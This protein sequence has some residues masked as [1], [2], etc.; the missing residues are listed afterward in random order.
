MNAAGRLRAGLL[1]SLLGCLAV[2][3]SAD[4]NPGG[5]IDFSGGSAG[6][7]VLTFL[8]LPVAA[9]SIG[10]GAASLTTDEEATAFQANPAMIALVPDYY[11]S[12]SHAEILGEFRHEN[13]AFTVPTPNYGNFGGSANILAATAFKDARDIDENPATPSAYDI[14]LGLTYGTNLV[15]DRVSAGGRLDLLRSNLDGDVA[16]GYAVSAGLIFMLVSDMR[17]ALIVNN[18]SHGINY[19][20]SSQ[21]PSEPLPINVGLELGKPLL[22]TRWSAQAGLNQGNDGILHFYAGAEWRV[23]KYLVLRAG[24]EGASQDRE[25]GAFGGAAGGIGIKYDRITL[26]YG[27]KSLGPLGDYH[28]F[29]LSYSRK[30]KFRARDE[31][32]LEKALDKYGSGKYASALSL[33]RAAIAANP[34]NFKAQALA[35]KIQL[36]MDRLDGL[37]VTIA[38]TANTDGK[39][40]SEWINGQPVGGLPRRKTKL[41][42]M[43]GAGGKILIVD[44]GD[45]TS[46]GTDSLKVNYVHGAYAQM[47]YD[48]V[49][50][51]AAE[52]RM[53]ADRWDYRLPFL[54]TQRPLSDIHGGLLTEKI[55]PIKHGAEVMLL[56]AMDPRL[57]RSEAV[58]GKELEAVAEALHRRI[59]QPKD[60]RILVLLLHGDL[61]EACRVAK[62]VPEL[63]A[64]ILSG[65]AQALRSPMK[66]GKTLICSPGRGGTN[67]G[68]LTLQLT[69]KGRIRSFRHFLIPLD[70]GVPEDL[71]LKQFLAPATLDP[72]AIAMDDY[73]GDFR[74]QII[75][76]VHADE[77]GKGGDLFLRDLLSGKDYAVPAPGLACSRPALGYGKNRV[78]FAGEDESGA[79]EIYAYQPGKDKLD[80]LTRLGGQAG[81]L[82]WILH[83]NALLAI[84][85]QGGKP[86]LLRIDPWSREVRDLTKGRFGAIRGFDLDKNGERLVLNADDGNR[87]T[88]WVTN[89]DMASAMSI[90]S[91]RSF[92]G[93]PR[94]NPQGDKVA[95]LVAGDSSALRDPAAAPS[96]A[97]GPTGELRIFDFA[98]KSLLKGTQQSRVRSFS[99]SADGKRI[100]Y[101]AGVNLADVNA[102]QLDSL[103]FVKVTPGTASP[104]DE[105]NPVPKVLDTR[106]GIL[107]EAATD[108]A[109]K[110]LWLDTRTRAEKILIDSAG[111]NSLK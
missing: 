15:S 56:G 92:I 104:R 14:A 40:S 91:D 89:L 36:E 31:V 106:E 85:A 28:A 69:G 57:A 12:V 50:V 99:W 61:A 27:Y 42:Q 4:L 35:Q 34:Y 84:Y 9:R 90:A 45:L 19:N 101:S 54:S 20:T 55:L 43:K 77:P 63:D 109:R 75:A 10:M 66:A 58:G 105:E 94:W 70:A 29:T 8:K 33:A 65:E 59:G 79:R 108:G 6:V 93:S 51:G 73:D 44:A 86:D 68:E 67:I 25:L 87:S 22:D 95:F 17:L 5:L 48:A 82:R 47:P 11:Y 62:L 16:N 7:P 74:A 30:S 46:A 111:Y 53:G 37:A 38:Y 64:I 52:L 103:T 60:G 2:P 39:M 1:A 110:I 81:D 97:P 18:L 21:S 13:L 72:N 26:D 98:S 80:T 49:N 23:I 71:E 78:A 76:Y 88:L 96:V 83:N 32:L 102:F 41:M 100:F 107:F 24:Y 3:S